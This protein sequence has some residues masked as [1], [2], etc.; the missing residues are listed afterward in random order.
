MQHFKRNTGLEK[1]VIWILQLFQEYFTD[2]DFTYTEPIVK[3]RLAKNRDCEEKPP[4][5]PY[6]ELCSLICA[7]LRFEFTVVTYKSVFLYI[8]P[9]KPEKKYTFSQCV[10]STN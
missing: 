1:N 7:W 8:R 10:K 2:T 4:D 9:W 3:I 5:V 6:A